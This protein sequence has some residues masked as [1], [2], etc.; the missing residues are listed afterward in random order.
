[1]IK[2]NLLPEK[3]HRE[4][5]NWNQMLQGY[6]HL[7]M[8]I[9]GGIG[10]VIIILFLVIVVYPRL[11]AR[12]LRKLTA[13]WEG[14]EKEYKE[15]VQLKGEQ[16]KLKA[17]QQNIKTITSG[18]ILW[19]ARLNDVS[20]ALPPEIQLTELSTQREKSAEKGERIV[21]VISGRVP[22]FPGE[23][24]IGNFIKGLR[25]NEGFTADFSEIRP[26][27]S[28]T[29]AEGYKTFTLKCYTSEENED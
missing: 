25:Q 23:Q 8:P 28:K 13:R 4:K 1:M 29:T 14:M 10:A 22:A 5:T 11:Q 18:S 16:K 7:T 2:I 24:A 12:T 19:A 3:F 27:S 6:K 17:I 21:L 26:P 9:L 20:D 15:V